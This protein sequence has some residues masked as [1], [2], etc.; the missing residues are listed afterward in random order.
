MRFLLVFVFLL[1]AYLA[2]WWPT[3]KWGP[4]DVAEYK[5]RNQ[6]NDPNQLQEAV[7]SLHWLYKARMPLIVTSH[8]GSTFN[9]E[10]INENRQY[11]FWLFGSVWKLPFERRFTNNSPTE[12]DLETLMGPAKSFK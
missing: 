2:C 4:R 1:C 10:V 7:L 8:E 12:K 6:L 3:R 5:L 9:S 11:Y